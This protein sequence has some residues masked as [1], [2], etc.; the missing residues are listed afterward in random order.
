MEL[1]FLGFSWLSDIH[2]DDEIGLLNLVKAVPAVAAKNGTDESLIT[3]FVS[4][5]SL[6]SLMMAQMDFS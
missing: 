1:V 2:Q 3:K 5:D 6:N 4:R